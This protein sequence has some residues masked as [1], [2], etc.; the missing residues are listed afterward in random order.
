MRSKLILNTGN[1]TDITAYYSEWFFNRIIAGS[2]M[3]RNPFNPKLVIKYDLSPSTIDVICFCTKNPIPM[4]KRIEELKD[5]NQFWFV[6]ITPYGKDIEPN[7]P[8]KYLVIESFKKISKIV[9]PN[10]V[11]WR[12][13]AIFINEKYTIEYHIRAFEKMAKEMSGYTNHCHRKV[14]K[15]VFDV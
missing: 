8:N 13:D 3:V 9:G 6:T 12:Y 11:G 15:C 2:V 1:R 7:V 14:Y 5:F 10:S 4:L